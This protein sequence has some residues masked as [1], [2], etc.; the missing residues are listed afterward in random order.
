MSWFSWFSLQDYIL[1]FSQK[2]PLFHGQEWL[3]GPVPRKPPMTPQ[4]DTTTGH[5]NFDHFRHFDS[6]IVSKRSLVNHGDR[7]WCSRCGTRGGWVVGVVPG[8]WGGAGHGRSLVPPRG[9]G[10]GLISPLCPHCF[11]T[12]ALLGPILTLLDPILT[13]FGPNSDPFWPHFGL[14]LAWFWPKTTTF[15][16]L[17]RPFFVNFR[18]FTHF[19]HFS[20]VLSGP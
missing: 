1:Y 3:P 11:P 17:F 8:V 9:M 5:H 7:P 10:P 2:S 15:R 16:T 18:K 12:V 4:L 20:Q 6:L 13:L 14:I 19:G